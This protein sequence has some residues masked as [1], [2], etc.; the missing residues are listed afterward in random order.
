MLQRYL[1]QF[2]SN[3]K[4]NLWL[5]HLFLIQ[6]KV[7]RARSKTMDTKMRTHLFIPIPLYDQANQWNSIPVVSSRSQKSLLPEY[8]E[9]TYEV[10][11]N[12]AL[13]SK[14]NRK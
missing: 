1:S 4:I 3:E 8:S 13:V 12:T 6:D 5:F 7:N 9:L 10:K 14:G 11:L 2:T